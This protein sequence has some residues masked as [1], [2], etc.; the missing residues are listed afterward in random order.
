MKTSFHLKHRRADAPL[1]VRSL[2]NRWAAR[3]KIISHIAY[4][5]AFAA[6]RFLE[7]TVYSHRRFPVG[8]YAGPFGSAI[9]GKGE[10]VLS[11]AQQDQ[12]AEIER[13]TSKTAKPIIVSGAKLVQALKEYKHHTHDGLTARIVDMVPEDRVFIIGEDMYDTSEELKGPKG[14]LGHLPKE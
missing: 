10:V 5:C 14:P 4:V 9:N 7:N 11:Q 2:A 1:R 3:K 13:A 12:I 8:G 6:T